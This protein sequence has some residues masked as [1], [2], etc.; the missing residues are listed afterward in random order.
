[1]RSQLLCH[2]VTKGR[3]HAVRELEKSRCIAGS[4]AVEVFHCWQ[5]PSQC[6]Q[7][8]LR[9]PRE[10]TFEDVYFIAVC[11]GQCGPQRAVPA[12][13]A[14]CRGQLGKVFPL[15]GSEGSNESGNVVVGVHVA[16]ALSQ[17]CVRECLVDGR[18]GLSNTLAVASS[19]GEPPRRGTDAKRNQ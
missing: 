10:Q 4:N 2:D 11:S 7:Q 5:Q 6:Q 16:S 1:M 12:S 18:A 17:R 14:K 8:V 13:L 19:G 9:R 15:R 3:L